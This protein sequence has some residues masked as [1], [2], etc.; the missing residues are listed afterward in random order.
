MQVTINV[1]ETLPPAIMKLRIQEI[2]KSL[3]EEAIRLA[4]ANNPLKQKST[5]F[6]KIMSIAN[7][8]AQLPSLDSRSADEILGYQQSEIGLWDAE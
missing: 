4:N 2:E 1:P 8:C 3:Q 6:L 7:E 5:K